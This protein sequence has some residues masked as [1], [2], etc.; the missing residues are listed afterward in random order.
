VIL[1]FGDKVPDHRRAAFVAPSADLIGAVTLGDDA[2]VW[3]HCV[4][5]GDLYW[6]EVGPRT[7]LQDGTVVHVE[8]GRAP[9][10]I[11]AEVTVGHRAILHGCRVGDR[12]LIGMGAVLLSDVVVG[13]GSVV[14]AGSVLTEGFEV[15]PR[16]LVA[17]APASVRRRVDDAA[18]ERIRRAADHYVTLARSHSVIISERGQP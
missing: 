7:N 6:I 9:A 3:Y 10:R 1:P 18:L 8:T 13:E 11:G 16:S 15:P 5:R 17:G 2:S 12:C 4:L 14:A